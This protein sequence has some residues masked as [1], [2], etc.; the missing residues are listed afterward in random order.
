MYPIEL[1]GTVLTGT[2]ISNSDK[3]KYVEITSGLGYLGSLVSFPNAAYVIIDG[4]KTNYSINTA[5]SK[6]YDFLPV[7]E[8]LTLTNVAFNNT[9]LDFRNCNRLRKLDLRGCSKISS[10]IFPEGRS[11]SKVILPACIK[12][13]S[14]LNNPNLSEIEFENGTK[15][16]N[17]TINCS[18]ISSEFDVTSLIRTYF[19]FSNAELLKLTGERTLDLDVVTS[20]S[21][22]GSK[23]NLI[24]TYTILNTEG[25]P[26]DISYQLKKDLVNSFGDIDSSKNPVDFIYTR[27]PLSHAVFEEVVYGCRYV[28]GSDN[29]FYPFDSIYFKKGNDV[30]ITDGALDIT[31]SL[32]SNAPAT[33]DPFTGAVAVTGNSTTEYD[34]SVVIKSKEAGDIPISGKIH[35]GYREPKIGDYAYADGTF[36][37][38]LIKSKTV[39][40]MVFAKKVNESDTSKLDLLVLGTDTVDGMCGPDWYTYNKRF[41]IDKTNG[42]NQSKVYELLTNLFYPNPSTDSPPL[43]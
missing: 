38:T 22:L 26:A 3:Y 11:L 17:L 13:I 2:S 1:S 9:V 39:V 16:T 36:S 43:S 32:S 23:A 41:Q 27:T 31:Y 19:D 14:I 29:I 8:E 4:I 7:I 25:Y 28:E 12:S 37:K 42:L 24:G 15:L 10:V 5:E 35:F 18:G 34:Y 33:I 21:T 40:G 6:I 20:I 30:V